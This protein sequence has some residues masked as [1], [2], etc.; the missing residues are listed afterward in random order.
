MRGQ[1]KR[2]GI[3][4]DW[5]REIATCEPDYYRWNQWFFIR[6]YEKGMAY[7]KKG[8]VNWCPSCLT[9][10]ANEQVIDG[11]CWRC[12][13]VVTVEQA[14]AMVLQNHRL[15]RSAAAITGYSWPADWPEK[16]ITM[17][18]NWIGKN[19]GTLIDFSVEGRTRKNP[20]IHHP[21]R[22]HFRRNVCGTR[23]GTSAAGK[24][25]DTGVS[26]EQAMKLRQEQVLPGKEDLEKNGTS[27]AG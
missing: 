18:R 7:R 26:G 23:P 19:Q 3:S 25:S 1:L 15:C 8:T 13:S 6:L 9:V 21:H 24:Y 20:R 14:R 5:S 2:L 10:L 4:Y 16:V 17:Q 12:D 22:H 11:R 27:L